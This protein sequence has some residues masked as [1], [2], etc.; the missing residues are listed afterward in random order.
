MM[1]FRSLLFD[2]RLLILSLTYSTTTRRN[3]IR[4]R[5]RD[6]NATV[7]RWYLECRKFVSK[8]V[9]LPLYTWQFS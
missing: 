9:I 4:A 2:W 6:P 1:L 3:W 7:P 8:V 5:R